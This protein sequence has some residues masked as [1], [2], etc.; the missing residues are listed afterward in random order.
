MLQLTPYQKPQPSF[1]QLLR[2]LKAAVTQL[3]MDTARLGALV[4][5]W[6][7]VHFVGAFQ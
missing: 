2:A 5:L 4:V 7:I 1:A 3:L 6:I